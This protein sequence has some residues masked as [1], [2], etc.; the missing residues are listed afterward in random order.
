[1]I[2]GA[3]LDWGFFWLYFFWCVFLGGGLVVCLFVVVV[4]VFFGFLVF[5]FL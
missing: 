2:G 4:G 3:V 5:V 1:M